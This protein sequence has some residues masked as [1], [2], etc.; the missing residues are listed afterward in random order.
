LRFFEF[1]GFACL[2][3]FGILMTTGTMMF[4]GDGVSRYFY[5]FVPI[6]LCAVNLVIIFYVNKHLR[7]TGIRESVRKRII[8]RQVLVFIFYLPYHLYYF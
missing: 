2:I 7:D 6:L 5:V 1:L 4:Y 8:T 3:A